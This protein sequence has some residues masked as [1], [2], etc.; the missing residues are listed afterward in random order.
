MDGMEWMGS[1]MRAARGALDVATQNLAN[2]SSDGY[3]KAQAAI[4]LSTRGLAVSTHATHEQGA[5][6]HTGRAFD[7]ALLGEGAFRVGDGTTR[8]GAFVRDRDGRLVDDRGRALR[9][10]CGVVHV[11]EHATIA[12]DG[13][14][15]DGG[16]TVDRL[17]LPAG[18][19]VL[20]GALETSTVNPVGETL[21]ILTAQRAFE[22]A[23]KTMLAID[24]TREKSANDVVRVQ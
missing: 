7:L 18:T 16:R 4:T 15:R 19:H 9:G 3:R 21:A 8:N 2:A 14:I 1:A 12:A 17:A 13:T 6:R 11:S 22:T 10:A 24:A 20:S 23:Q 5:V